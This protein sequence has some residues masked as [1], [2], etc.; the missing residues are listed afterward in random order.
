[1]PRPCVVVVR[2]SQ[3]AR[4]AQ[5]AELAEDRLRAEDVGENV[6]LGRD[7]RLDRPGALDAQ[8]ADRPGR[9]RTERRSQQRELFRVDPFESLARLRRLGGRLDGLGEL[10]EIVRAGS[11]GE[12]QRAENREQASKGQS[13]IPK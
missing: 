11:C 6:A 4:Q 9:F 12:R 13:S 10:L 5:R 7:P 8:I 1:M 2:P 3:E